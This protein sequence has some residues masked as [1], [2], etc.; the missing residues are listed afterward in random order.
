MVGLAV[1][2]RPKPAAKEDLPARLPARTDIPPAMRDV[3]RTKMGQHE[4]QMRE[5][6]TRV[7]VMDDDGIA[8]AAGAVFDEP[9][10]AR[11]I[12]GDELNS[13]L[14]ERFFVL[15]DEMRMRARQLVIA[16]GHHDRAAVTDQFAAL[17][18]VCLACHDAYLHL[19]ATTSAHGEGAP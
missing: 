8:R 2:L 6:M 17:T 10:L 3:V 5:L 18:R 4:L 15:Q 19:N 9:S 16:S 11:P 13:V 14:P 12:T 7:V 1:L